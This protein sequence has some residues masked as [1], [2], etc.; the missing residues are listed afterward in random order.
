MTDRKK[1]EN[2]NEI[3]YCSWLDLPCDEI[4][5]SDCKAIMSKF[6]SKERLDK[7]IKGMEC[8]IKPGGCSKGCPYID[9]DTGNCNRALN[10]D[11]L[12]LLKK[13]KNLWEVS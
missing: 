3:G 8:C 2:R 9:K 10:Y 5:E 12:D 6:G 4:C 7:A 13:L 1:C 11:V